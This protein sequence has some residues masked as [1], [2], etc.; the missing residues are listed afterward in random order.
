MLVQKF[1]AV[2][3]RPQPVCAPNWQTRASRASGPKW[4]SSSVPQIALDVHLEHKAG[5]RQKTSEQ[6]F[7]IA[8]GTSAFDRKWQPLRPW[9]RQ[10]STGPTRPP[11][12]PYHSLAAMRGLGGS[13]PVGLINSKWYSSLL[14]RTVDYGT[15]SRLISIGDNPDNTSRTLCLVVTTPKTRA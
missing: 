6:T 14:Y 3:L 13:G 12:I 11:S 7:R 2:C 9:P 8:P 1:I 10:G 4:L 15:N 5:E